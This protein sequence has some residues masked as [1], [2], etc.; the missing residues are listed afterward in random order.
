MKDDYMILPCEIKGIE[1]NKETGFI[2]VEGYSSVYD[3]I[4]LG[5]DRVRPSFFVEDLAKRGNERPALWQ[6]N[7]AEPLGTK[8]FSTDGYGLKFKASLPMDDTFV[9][10]RVFPQLKAGSVRGVS[11]GYRTEKEEYNQELKCMDLVKGKLKESSFVTFAMCEEA[12]VLSVRKQAKNIKEGKSKGLDAD[13]KHDVLSFVKSIG[14]DIETETKHEFKLYPLADE[15]T[16]W[17]EKEAIENIKSNTGCKDKPSKNYYKGFLDFDSDSDSFDEYRLP[18]VKYIDNEFRIVPNAIYEIA[19]SLNCKQGFEDVKEFINSVYV[20]MGKEEPFKAGNK[21]FVD[22]QTLKN[23]RKSDLKSVFDN[24]NVILSSGS[25]EMI[26]EALRSG[27][28]QGSVSDGDNSS[29]LD[30]LKKANE[31]MKTI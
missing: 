9:M 26:I 7:H 12:T 28:S 5:F 24:E 25:K 22:K 8:V 29:I 21:F 14:M 31:D 18:Y 15:K 11:I 2:E 16:E 13:Y 20:K 10:G 3:V 19:G 4:D 23:M 1:A 30:A 6:H 17:N 27:D